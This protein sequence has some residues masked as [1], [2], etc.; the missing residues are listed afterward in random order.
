MKPV[1]PLFV[2]IDAC[3]WEILRRHS[4]LERTAPTRKRLRSVF[5]YS[6]TCV[7]SILS[8]RWPSEHRNW[9]YFVYD[10]PRSPFR[11]LRPLRWLPPALTRR[12]F[13]RRWLARFVRARLG[14]R[15]Y[16]DLYNIPFRYIHLFDFT[17][18]RSPLAPAGMN[19][20]S[21]IFDFLAVRDIPYFV[22][23]TARSEEANRDALLADIR[24]ER[25]EFAFQYW[26]GLDGLL[27]RVGN[28]SP[29]I[30]DRLHL[31][32]DWIERILAEA[33]EHYREVH[34]YVFSDHGMANCDRMLDLKGRI[35][36]LPARMERDYAVV[37]DSTMARFWFFDPAA[38]ESIT[39]ELRR[40]PEG[41][42]LSDDELEGLHARF[43]DRYFGELV[44]LVEEGVLIVPS[45][46]GE[47]PIR[48]MHGYHPDAPQ[49]FA[50][51]LTNRPSVPDDVTD[52][53]HIYRLMERSA[54]LAHDRV[55]AAAPA[56]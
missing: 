6:S 1:L 2:M 40:I 41:R 5:G 53:P 15:G 56:G 32:Q 30:A 19:R 37:Y 51:L 7:P 22:T 44:F 3:G 27:H 43:E 4:F 54:S 47:R 16:F 12:R 28:Q 49:S 36:A 39:A 18:K 31:Y 17:E 9:C 50:A 25:I 20:G 23:D 8:G 10:P 38:R 46:M 34:L 29:E 13:F 14:F 21:N 33:K 48:G 55:A 45:H 42:I 26:A 52:I 11:S 35:D 24:A